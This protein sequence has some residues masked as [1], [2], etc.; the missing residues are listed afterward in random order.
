MTARVRDVIAAATARLAAV[1]VASPRVDAEL[2]VAHVLRVDRGRLVVVDSLTDAE[3]AELTALVGRR[4]DREPLQHILGDAAFGPVTLAVGPG[5]FVP[6]PETELLL[7]WAVGACARAGPAPR[8]VDLCSGSGA[9][10]LGVAALTDATVVAV[11]KDADALI[12]LRRNVTDAPEPWRRRVEV[13]AGDAT[14]L[15]WRHPADGPID[16]VVS[17]PPYVPSTADVTPEVAHDPDVAVFGGRDGMSVI[18]PMVAAIAAVLVPGGRCAIEHDDT[19]A[20][21]VAAA[22]DATDAFDGV[23]AHRDLT[24]RPRFVSARRRSDTSTAVG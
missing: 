1:G 17:N 18:T 19:T 21:R 15:D 9:L 6:R 23:V 14:T 12:W 3:H 11:E 24:G 22:L 4:A 20:D 7:E 13:R 5:V 16:V 8:V 2:L 10:A